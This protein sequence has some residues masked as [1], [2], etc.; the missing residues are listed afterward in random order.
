[1]QFTVYSCERNSLYTNSL[2]F[3][4][5]LTAMLHLWNFYPK[6][7]STLESFACVFTKHNFSYLLWYKVLILTL[8]YFCY[9]YDVGSQ[10][11]GKDLVRLI[12]GDVKTAGQQHG[13][14]MLARCIQCIASLPT[15]LL[16]SSLCCGLFIRPTSLWHANMWPTHYQ[17]VLKSWSPWLTEVWQGVPPTSN[18]SWVSALKRAAYLPPHSYVLKWDHACCAKRGTTML[19][20]VH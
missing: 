2:S 6:L 8:Q 20:I 10:A 19:L 16:L 17:W 18:S 1:M 5:T 13:T 7:N 9:P 14:R 12:C 4:V 11:G 15:D 3:S